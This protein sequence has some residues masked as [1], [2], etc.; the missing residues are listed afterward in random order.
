MIVE[1]T[2]N[3]ESVP[4]E[5]RCN[6]ENKR[7]K[8]TLYMMGCP[9]VCQS[10][11]VQSMFERFCQLPEHTAPAEVER[12]SDDIDVGIEPVEDKAPT[13]VKDKDE[14]T[15]FEKLMAGWFE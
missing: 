6:P 11:K 7:S 4:A 9:L 12:T 10:K 15:A 13:V 5:I 8:F 3:G 2:I 14:P 1:L